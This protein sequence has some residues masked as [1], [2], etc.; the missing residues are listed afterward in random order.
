MGEQSKLTTAGVAVDPCEWM[1][2]RLRGE[3]LQNG[4]WRLEKTGEVQYEVWS[5]P[6]GD[7][8]A[9]TAQ[10]AQIAN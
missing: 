5:L 10:T 3:R 6:Y 1:I 9:Q 7:D 8:Y 2:L 4:E